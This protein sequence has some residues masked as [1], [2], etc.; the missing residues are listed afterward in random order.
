[1]LSILRIAIDGFRKWF[2]CLFFLTLAFVLITGCLTAA[3]R[4][5]LSMRS[6]V[7]AANARILQCTKNIENNPAHQ[8]LISHTPK[9]KNITPMHMADTAI[10]AEEDVKN[11]IAF[12]NEEANCRSLIIESLTGIAPSMVTIFIQGFQGYDLITADL[13]ERKI[14]WGAA[15]KRKLAVYDETQA[16]IKEEGSRID[17]ELQMSHEAELSRRQALAAGLSDAL[18][19]WGKQQQYL[20]DRLQNQQMINSLNRPVMTN[21]QRFGNSINCT[22]Y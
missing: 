16:K 12:Y 19:E 5:T 13:I 15:N 4:K 2:A 21:C 17:Q 3:Q 22:S 8:S 10:P 20:A 14:S 6:D 7:K 18:T 1:M 11:I 9:A